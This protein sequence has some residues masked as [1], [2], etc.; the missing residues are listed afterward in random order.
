MRIET[1]RA[2]IPVSEESVRYLTV[3]VSARDSQRRTYRPAANV[4]LVLDRSGSMDGRK[5]EMARAAV[6]HAIRLLDSRDHLAVVVYDNDVDAILESAN[7]SAESKAL[8]LKR[9]AAV[10]ARGNTDLC[11]GWSRGIAE[12]ARHAAPSDAAAGV[13]RVLLLTDGLA[14]EGVTDHDELARLAAAF[15]AKGITTSTFGVGADFDETLL[16]RLATEGGGH[17]YFIES[18]RQIPDFLASELSETLEVVAP[19]A[20]FVIRAGPD[21]EI[22]VVND[23]RVDD[24]A[25]GVHVKLGDLVAS[26]NLQVVLALRWKP[27]LEGTPA[28]ADCSLT[29]RAGVLFPQPMRVEWTT[30]DAAANVTQPVNPSVLV[31]VA[32]LIAARAVADAL[33]ANRAGRYDEARAILRTAADRL[34]AMARGN[35]QINAIA[36]ELEREEPR[37]AGIMDP[38]TSKAQHFVAHSTSRGRDK[39]GKARRSTV[40]RT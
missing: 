38:V 3:T 29:D 35:P 36:D 28:F 10:D 34:R 8:A 40:G 30:A 31:A 27:R 15:R 13:S 25:D 17:F 18:P 4:A 24:K 19:D 9:L 11:G 37:Y 1:D 16:S 14:N 2:L 39:Q 26:Q 5:I 12:I 22:V 7:A 6:A 23:F 21:V 32:E 33:A 20:E